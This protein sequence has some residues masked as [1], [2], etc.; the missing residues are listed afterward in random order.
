MHTKLRQKKSFQDF[1]KKI[2]EETSLDN[3]VSY[4]MNTTWEIWNV[5][6]RMYST[7]AGWR[8]EKISVNILMNRRIDFT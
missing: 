7:D 6:C 2:E 3:R 4:I 5:G 1:G 8:P